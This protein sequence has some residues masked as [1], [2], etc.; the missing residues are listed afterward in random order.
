MLIILG[1]F[2]NIKGF[3]GSNTNEKRLNKLEKA[4][5]ENQD[6]LS[7]LKD[8]IR[9]IERQLRNKKQEFKE[10]SGNIKDILKR[11][12][13]RGFENIEKMKERQKYIFRNLDRIDNIKEKIKQG[14]ISHIGEGVKEKE[15][16]EVIDYVADI[17]NQLRD[18]DMAMEDLLD[19]DYES[20]LN[21]METKDEKV[22][23]FAEKE[24]KVDIEEKIEFEEEEDKG[25]P[26]E[27]EEKFETLE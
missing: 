14:K 26:E 2:D 1:V 21:N 7:D 5:R 23:K 27:L 20:M 13:K 19:E 18:K 17:H 12:M 9:K 4:E 6:E 3:L 24:V 11:E 10:A 22:E 8:D 16:D 15:I 25:L